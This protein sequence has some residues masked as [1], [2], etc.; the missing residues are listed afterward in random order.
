MQKKNI[1][2][3]LSCLLYV[4][5][6]IT[7]SDWIYS[8][9]KSNVFDTQWCFHVCQHVFFS[10]SFIWSQTWLFFIWLQK[11][12]FWLSTDVVCSDVKLKCLFTT[13]SPSQTQCV[14]ISW[15]IHIAIFCIGSHFCN[16]IF[17]NI[18]NVAEDKMQQ[19]IKYTV[20]ISGKNTEVS[21]MQ[22][23]LLFFF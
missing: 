10:V 11:R 5:L 3:V 6:W 9:Y 19:V 15:H 16:I 21:T 20:K 13:V 8:L 17:G 12:L 1:Q 22:C 14:S 23:E 4:P 7:C 18:F 2:F